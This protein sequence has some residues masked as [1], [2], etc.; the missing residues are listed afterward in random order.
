MGFRIN[1]NVMAM[2]TLSKMNVNSRE[3]DSSLQKLSSGLR[4]NS[5]ADDASGMMIANS[6]RSQANSLGQAIKNANDGIGLI[7]T[8]DGALDEYTNIIN[9]IKT[10]AIQA[11]SDGQTSET[12]KAIQSDINKL[13]EGA[14]SIS[15]TTS[16]NG[17]NLLDGSYTNKK[18]QVGAYAN[19]TIGISISSTQ[20]NSIGAF[21][22]Q[23][24]SAVT[25]TAFGAADFSINGKATGASVADS[26][27]GANTTAHSRGSA[28]AKANAI[29]SIQSSTG[30]KATAETEVTG[31][32]VVGGSLAVGGMTINGI[33]VG[34]VSVSANDR[35][36]ALMNAINAISNKTNVTASHDGGKL[37]LTSNDGS[38]I[39]IAGTD[40]ATITGVSNR[41]TGGKITL[42]SQNAITVAGGRVA[43]GGFTATTYSSSSPLNSIDVT[44]SK[45]AQ[46]RILQATYALKDLD[47]VRSNMGSIQNQLTSTVNNIS[48][49][50]VNV[51]SAESQIREVDFAEESANFSS[52]QIL[53]QSATYALSQA[54]SVQQNV[55]RLLQ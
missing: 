40:D 16:F 15:S 14:Q 42:E 38:D 51:K 41:T 20:I 10:K 9:S 22:Y 35:D 55:L 23:E 6:L 45:G 7:Q 12:R 39:T 49:T 4:I 46:K 34:A 47:E 53:A 2:N 43:D 5:A 8:A 3:L 25:T 26:A 27:S 17:M 13:L 11:A 29:N 32:S 33:D 50:Q 30:V 52:K 48:V 31:A 19:Q 1:T 21:G 36:N 54:N 37:V 44:T 28:W 18:F 24:G